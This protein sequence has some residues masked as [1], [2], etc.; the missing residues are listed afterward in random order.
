MP[1]L[2][3]DIH[4][5]QLILALSLLTT[6]FL[7]LGTIIIPKIISKLIILNSFLIRMQIKLFI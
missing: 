2:F 1:Q 4:F 7:M 6:M 3:V 5:E